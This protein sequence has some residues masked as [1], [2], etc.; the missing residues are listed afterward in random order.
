MLDGVQASN[1]SE[2]E[3]TS[4][5]AVAEVQPVCTRQMLLLPKIEE[6]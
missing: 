3:G 1:S 2:L 6:T 4:G 5:C